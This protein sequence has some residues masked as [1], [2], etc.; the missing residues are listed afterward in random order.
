MMTLAHTQVNVLFA[1]NVITKDD[2]GLSFAVMPLLSLSWLIIAIWQLR[3]VVNGFKFTLSMMIDDFTSQLSLIGK[4]L[5]IGF[6][7]LAWGMG[8]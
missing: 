3:L 5:G 7:S 1:V 8:L 2:N 4:V 6:N